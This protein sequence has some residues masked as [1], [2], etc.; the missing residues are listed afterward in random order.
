MVS[1]SSSSHR[2]YSLA[3]SYS[4]ALWAQYSNLLIKS[5]SES[6]YYYPCPFYSSYTV[7][8]STKLIS[9]FNSIFFNPIQITGHRYSKCFNSVA[10]C[11]QFES[12]KPCCLF[13]LIGHPS[14]YRCQMWDFVS[15]THYPRRLY[16]WNCRKYAGNQSSSLLAALIPFT[17]S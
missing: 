12:R 15:R 8:S 17:Y 11:F 3:N 10:A 5:L 2:D 13:R 16:R 7:S 4:V 14:Y 9:S 1:D 6:T